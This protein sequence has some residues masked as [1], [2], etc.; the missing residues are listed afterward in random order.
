MAKTLGAIFLTRTVYKYTKNIRGVQ[1]YNS[2][3]SSVV[4]AEVAYGKIC[5]NKLQNWYFAPSIFLGAP[6]DP[7]GSTLMLT[8]VWPTFPQ[9]RALRPIGSPTAGILLQILMPLKTMYTV[10][11]KKTCQ[12]IFCSVWVKYEPISITIGS[13]VLE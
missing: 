9:T 3:H 6:V 2:M 11:Q 4:E 7:P 5:L 12:H 1:A 10:S 13:H 8:A